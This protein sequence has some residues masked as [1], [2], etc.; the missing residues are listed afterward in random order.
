MENQTITLFGKFN[1]VV[2]SDALA[3][4]IVGIGR[5]RRVRKR[6]SYAGG[7]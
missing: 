3:F 7:I 4:K 1:L 2:P 6:G 5:D